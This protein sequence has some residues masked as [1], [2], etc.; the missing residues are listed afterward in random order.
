MAIEQIATIRDLSQVGNFCD[1]LEARCHFAG[2]WMWGLKFT[3]T[4][5]LSKAP[6]GPITFQSAM[7]LAAMYEA[8]QSRSE[9]PAD[10][11][12]EDLHYVSGQSRVHYRSNFCDLILPGDH[13]SH[14]IDLGLVHPVSEGEVHRLELCEPAK[15]SSYALEKDGAFSKLRAQ[16]LRDQAQSIIHA[17]HLPGCSVIEGAVR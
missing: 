6:I 17:L 2:T 15:T 9:L 3:A 7:V 10:H 11:S 5:A 16:D 4:P 14:L 8:E 13:A 1:Q 12:A